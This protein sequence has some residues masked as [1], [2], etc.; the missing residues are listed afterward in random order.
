M[1][2]FWKRVRG[3][4]MRLQADREDIG[5][6]TELQCSHFLS[7]AVKF[8]ERGS[9]KVGASSVRRSGRRSYKINNDERKA[10]VRHRDAF[11]RFV[12]AAHQVLRVQNA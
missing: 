3:M 2:E 1:L 10:L 9:S 5:R 4:G 8:E 7:T 11:A 6:R 12:A